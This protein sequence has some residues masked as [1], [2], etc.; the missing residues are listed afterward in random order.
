MKRI[1]LIDRLMITV[2][3]LSSATLFIALAYDL[4]MGRWFVPIT[5]IVFFAVGVLT[6]NMAGKLYIEE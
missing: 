3:N 4:G 2:G 5:P 6:W 1:P